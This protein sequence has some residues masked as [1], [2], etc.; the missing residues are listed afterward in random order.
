MKNLCNKNRLKLKTTNE[1]IYNPQ[2]KKDSYSEKGKT[3]LPFEG[4][5]QDGVCSK[6]DLIFKLRNKE[7]EGLIC[8]R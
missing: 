5:R 2:K 3:G 1:E 6:L 4:S 8:K 7:A